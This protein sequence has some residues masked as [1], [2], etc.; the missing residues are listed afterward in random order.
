M[1]TV[2]RGAVVYVAVD[3]ATAAYVA[4]GTPAWVVTRD[5]AIQVWI[6]GDRNPAGRRGAFGEAS[7]RPR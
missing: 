6:E 4:N 5:L 2:V 3:A 7:P 1:A